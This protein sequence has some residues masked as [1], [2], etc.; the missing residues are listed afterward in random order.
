M[1]KKNHF[2]N[3]IL[4][5]CLAAVCA[6]MQVLANEEVNP[7]VPSRE[8]LEAHI[9][10]HQDYWKGF[11]LRPWAERLLPAPPEV[12]DFLRKDNLYQGFSQQPKPARIDETYLADIHAA[13]ED[14]PAGVQ[15]L[16]SDK[17]VA[18]MLVDDLGGSGYMESVLDADGKP[19][20]A[21]LVLD[22]TV[23][24]RNANAWA[25][26]K[27]STPF[28][29]NLAYEIHTHLEEPA[30]NTRRN[31]LRYILLHEFGHFV[32]MDPAIH[33]S[34]SHE[35]SRE[36]LANA[37]FASLSWVYKDGDY[38]SRFDADFTLRPK[39]VFYGNF[40]SK[41]PAR[42]AESVLRALS[43]TDFPTPYA[44]TSN[45]DDFAE[46][47]ANFIHVVLDRRPYWVEVSKKGKVLYR[48]D[49]CWGTPRCA[50]K[51]KY[52]NELLAAPEVQ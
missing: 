3:W 30:G 6:P 28:R 52:L 13:L 49:S 25:S 27:D 19:V 34:W 8:E 24:D 22:P 39:I 5:L 47:L 48:L 43:K 21:F 29:T 40:Q 26:W 42:D 36:A 14:I 44:A 41:L 2:T 10:R 18:I 7:S 31:A 45:A 9:V 23:L 16:V 1:R 11:E 35:P 12:I 4:T 20:A 51:E 38:V 50:A 32:G 17:L 33:P 37:R 46:S 15:A